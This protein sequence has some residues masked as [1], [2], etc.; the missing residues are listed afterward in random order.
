MLPD[1]A[2]SVEALFR[3]CFEGH[4][5][6]PRFTG[7]DPNHT[8]FGELS[9]LTAAEASVVAGVE[10]HSVAAHVRHLTEALR[11]SNGWALQGMFVADF[12]A[13]WIERPVS[14]EE[15]EAMRRELR[16]AYE[17]VL[18]WLGNDTRLS[19]ENTMLWT[20][21]ILAHSAYHLGAIRQLAMVARGGSV[22][23]DR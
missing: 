7:H 15:W 11:G 16:S 6:L 10:A 19:D 2:K 13:A 23:S 5:S 18:E 9:G 14:E 4:P 3:E 17:S 8:L 20:M 22:S 21:S 12:D 1:A